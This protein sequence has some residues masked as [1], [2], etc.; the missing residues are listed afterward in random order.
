MSSFGPGGFFDF[1]LLSDFRVSRGSRPDTSFDTAMAPPE[2]EKWALN[3]EE[4]LNKLRH[5]LGKSDPSRS[6]PPSTDDSEARGRSARKSGKHG[7]SRS[8]YDNWSSNRSHRELERKKVRGERRSPSHN[9]SGAQDR[10]E[11]LQELGPLERSGRVPD[12]DRPLISTTRKHRTSESGKERDHGVVLASV[13][14]S[15]ERSNARASI[16]KIN[17][18]IS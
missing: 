18:S 1:R 6:L 10:K 11:T 15:T 5:A 9:R 2:G 14:G 7:A 4:K 16:G 12:G 17:Q 8:M 3:G 13:S